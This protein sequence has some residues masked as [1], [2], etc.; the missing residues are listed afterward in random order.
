MMHAHQLV[1]LSMRYIKFIFPC[2]CSPAFIFYSHL[3]NNWVMNKSTWWNRYRILLL[4]ASMN[5]SPRLKRDQAPSLSWLS[6]V[7]S[8]IVADPNN[9]I[10]NT[11]KRFEEKKHWPPIYLVPTQ[12]H[13]WKM[14]HV[15][16]TTFSV[17]VKHCGGFFSCPSTTL[18]WCII[19]SITN[20]SL[21]WNIGKP[22]QLAQQ[23]QTLLIFMMPRECISLNT[24]GLSCQIRCF[25]WVEPQ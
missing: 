20:F 22:V 17:V 19:N 21:L 23:M 25:A 2:F 15:T 5:S 4:C 11:I 8:R 12:G 7:A 6:E 10:C 18:S 3:V 9:E 16:D 13:S 1:I 24:S 14:V